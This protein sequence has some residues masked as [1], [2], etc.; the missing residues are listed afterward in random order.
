VTARLSSYRSHA[1]LQRDLSRCRACVEAGYELKS[2]PVRAPR[3]EPTQRA[4]LFGQ[5]PGPVEGLQRL[6][7]R[8]D[9]GQKLR[10]WLQLDEDEFYAAFYCASVTRCDPGRDA[11][12]RGDRTP[13][14]P[15][16]ELCAFWR[17]WELALLRPQLIVTVGL[18]ALRR[19]LGFTTL[20]PHVGQRYERDGAVVIPLPHPSGASSWPYAPGNRERL[21]RA[22]ELV[23]EELRRIYPQLK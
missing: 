5:A 4:Y 7:W 1:S 12:G 9:A 22:L 8:G 3:A 21:E 16:Q 11:S 10:R 23:H 13:E 19:Q 17:D 15:E 6:P 14:P 20:T 2:L 18:L